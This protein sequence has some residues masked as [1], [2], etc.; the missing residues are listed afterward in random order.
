MAFFYKNEHISCINYAEGF[1]KIFLLKEIPEGHVVER[2]YL[3]TTFLVFMLE[4]D[5]EIRYEVDKYF[6]PLVGYIFFLPKN[7]QITAYARKATTLL[8]CSFASDLK[9]CSRFSIQQLSRYVIGDISQEPYCLK[10]DERIQGFLPLLVSSLREGLGCVHYHQIK[11]DELFLYL[12]AGYTKEELALFFYPILG[13]DMEFKDF[14]LMNSRSIFD[15]KDFAIRANM[16]LSTFNRRFK[17]TFNATA[18]TW[19]LLR[20]Q[21]FVRSDV[22]LSNLPFSEIAEKYQF[23]STSYLI[24]FC[25]KYFGK[26]PNELRKKALEE[27]AGQLE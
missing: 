3:D 11:R 7:Q 1:N 5:V 12:R 24:T 27:K 17:E 21:E 9:L 4:G 13:K 8:L 2:Q 20:K 14:V 25:K 6:Y 15:V 19:L 26:T 16:S 10:L 18:K 23:S 22:T